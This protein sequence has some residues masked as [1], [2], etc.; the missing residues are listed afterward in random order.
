[1]A[2]LFLNNLLQSKSLSELENACQQ[3]AACYDFEHFIYA[4]IY[5]TSFIEPQIIILNGYPLEWRTHYQTQ[6]YLAVDPVVKHCASSV[7]P[8]NWKNIWPIL[9]PDSEEL[10]LMDEARDAGL[11]SGVTM[12]IHSPQTSL[13]MLSL[14]SHTSLRKS[15][16]QIDQVLPVLGLFSV[17]L[18][19]TIKQLLFR[20]DKQQALHIPEL[21]NRERDCLLW[22]AEGKTSEE[23][24][25]RMKISKNTVIFHL[26]NASAKL[27]TTNKIQ[28]VVRAITYGLIQP[29]HIEIN[30]HLL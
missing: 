28:A 10:K 25:D 18:H 12:P 23:T 8:L 4:A 26:K 7:I 3:V 27:G 1:M 19:E 9:E 5:P 17:Y 21:S 24:S 30:S 11:K 15:D 13:A 29:A 16:K 6:N 22:A 2:Q 20:T 14:A